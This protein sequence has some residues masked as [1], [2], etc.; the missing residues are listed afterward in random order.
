V[1]I[2]TNFKGSINKIKKKL[3]KSTFFIQDGGY[4]FTN[5]MTGAA[6]LPALNVSSLFNVNKFRHLCGLEAFAVSLKNY[7]LICVIKIL[8]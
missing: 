1:F 4:L 2:A 5:L 8:A 7:T 3:E 6:R